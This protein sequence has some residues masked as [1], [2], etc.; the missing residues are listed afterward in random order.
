MTDKDTDIQQL[1]PEKLTAGFSHSPIVAAGL[2]ALA[3]HLLVVLGTSVSYINDTWIDPE[4]AAARRAPAE[5]AQ[6]PPA[7]PA[8]ATQP[9]PATAPVA[10]EDPLLSR[11][12]DA[13]VVREITETRPAPKSPDLGIDLDDTNP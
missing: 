13:P 8:A 10:G 3:L 2:V 9:T 12:R 5:A 11:H 7:T 4:G 1:A 6:R